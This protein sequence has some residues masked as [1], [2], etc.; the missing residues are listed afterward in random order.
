M[1]HRKHTKHHTKWNTEK[2]PNTILRIK[3]RQNTI[4]QSKQNKDKGQ[5]KRQFRHRTN[6]RKKTKT[7]IKDSPK[8]NLDTGQMQEKKQKQR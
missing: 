6:A 7:K 8:D 4:H 3:H 2:I 5:S 1:K